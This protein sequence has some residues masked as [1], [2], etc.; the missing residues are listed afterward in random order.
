MF[1]DIKPTVV[2]CPI[3]GLILLGACKKCPHHV[4]YDA[5]L[6][7]VECGKISDSEEKMKLAPSTDKEWKPKW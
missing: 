3:E 2:G 6:K 5:Y 4:K 7:R 1:R